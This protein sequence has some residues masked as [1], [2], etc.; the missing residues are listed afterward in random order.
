MGDGSKAEKPGRH[1]RQ[2]CTVCAHKG[3]CVAACTVVAL[4]EAQAEVMQA[5]AA[6]RHETIVRDDDRDWTKEQMARAQEQA[7]TSLPR[8]PPK[9]PEKGAPP[10]C[11]LQLWRHSWC[12][13][14]LPACL[15]R[16]HIVL[17]ALANPP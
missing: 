9:A 7:A 17:Q 14:L 10:A 3:L 6:P 11:C 8:G 12:K 1:C 13:A 16:G 2:G 15:V 4:D 5:P